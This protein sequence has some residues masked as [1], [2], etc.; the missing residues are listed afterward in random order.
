M[1]TTRKLIS[2]LLFGSVVTVVAACANFDG[3]PEITI[4]GG[5]SGVLPDAAAPITLVF[6]KPFKDGTLAFKI[7]PLTLDE[8]G[9]LSDELPDEGARSELLS[10]FQY[11]ANG[12]IAGGKADVDPA[13]GSVT[14]RPDGQMPIGQKLALL[15]EPGLQNLAGIATTVRTRIAFAF[16]L[17]CAKKP[18]TTFP[19][20]GYFL[21]LN[22]EKPL[23]AQIQLFGDFAVDEATGEF[24]A[25]FTNADRNPD[26]GRCKTVSCGA[27]DACR[28]LP[29]EACVP[30]SEKIVS[31]DEFPDFVANGSPPTGY[32]VL[33][34]GCL[35]EQ[36]DGS[37]AMATRSVDL[38]V[39]SPA[40][41]VQGLTI[42]LNFK[43]DSANV[44]RGTGGGTGIQTFL[45]TSPLG[46]AVGTVLAR[47]LTAEQTP[48]GVPKA[49]GR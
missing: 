2:A 12:A 14:I 1:R 41:T 32:G 19:S 7:V 28:T 24:K 49:P 43:K 38:K 34:E 27:A 13:K 29:S 15:I 42:V 18:I 6:N 35:A 16:D 17:K 25:Q 4:Q 22:V 3:P 37:I 30:P 5:A 48:A 47:S 11:D 21:A 46:Q 36:P 8:E 33:A 23:G 31:L 40:V 10:I 20:G 39:T 44:L 26:R 45:G 9:N